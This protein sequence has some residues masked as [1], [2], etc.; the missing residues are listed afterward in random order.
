MP[1]AL[2]SKLFAHCFGFWFL[3]F[4]F[5]F[6]VFGFWFLVFGFW[7]LVFGFAKKSWLARSS[8]SRYSYLVKH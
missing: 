4:G 3:V 5:W 2:A 8:K 7:F 1:L 6:L